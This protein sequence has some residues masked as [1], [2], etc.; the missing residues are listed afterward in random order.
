MGMATLCPAWRIFTVEG[1]RLL[2]LHAT[3]PITLCRIHSRAPAVSDLL[4]FR[5]FRLAF[6]PRVDRSAF[7]ISRW[8]RKTNLAPGGAQKCR[9]RSCLA[10][11]RCPRLL[12][13]YLKWN[14]CLTRAPRASR[15]SLCIRARFN[16]DAN[17]RW[18]T[19]KSRR[20][21][22]AL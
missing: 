1:L 18:C 3:H 17:A 9:C 22:K 13:S 15:E 2:L 4:L 10:S 8:L 5:L 14:E 19:A 11:M 6:F 12:I 20:T 16:Q 7:N 21:G